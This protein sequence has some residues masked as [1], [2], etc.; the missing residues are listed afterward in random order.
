MQGARGNPFTSPYAQKKVLE[1]IR[2]LHSAIL[3][4]YPK[5]GILLSSVKD[6]I[7]AMG[8]WMPGSLLYACRRKSAKPIGLALLMTETM[9]AI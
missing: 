4:F 5:P 2:A 6:S 7:A 3:V 9:N 8:N 1:L